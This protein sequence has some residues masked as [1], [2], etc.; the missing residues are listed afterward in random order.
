MDESTENA[1]EE[2]KESDI[3]IIRHIDPCISTNGPTHNTSN[4]ELMNR[5]IEPQLV[6]R[7][8]QPF[9]LNLTLSRPYNE[10][11][12]GISFIFTVEGKSIV[13]M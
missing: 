10:Q 1:V 6:V 12:D 4:F 11:T 3:L 9:Q 7:R 5:Q 2:K 13:I 8:G